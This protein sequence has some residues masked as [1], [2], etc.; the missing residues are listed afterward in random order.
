MKKLYFLWICF[1]WQPSLFGQESE[2][3]AQIGQAYALFHRLQS[4]DNPLDYDLN[5]SRA[6]SLSDAYWKSHPTL[7][8]EQKLKTEPIAYICSSLSITCMQYPNHF[9]LQYDAALQFVED[10]RTAWKRIVAHIGSR[11]SS[12]KA[13]YNWLESIG[14]NK[15]FYQEQEERIKER[16]E[17]IDKK[18]VYLF[19]TITY[20]KQV[21][22]AAIDSLVV[23]IEL[24]FRLLSD[25]NTASTVTTVQNQ[26]EASIRNLDTKNQAMQSL[27]KRVAM[28][29]YL[30]LKT[31]L[32]LKQIQDVDFICDQEWNE[33]IENMN[34]SKLYLENMQKSVFSTA[35]YV[36]KRY[37]VLHIGML[38]LEDL[39]KQL[40]MIRTQKKPCS[41][42]VTQSD[43]AFAT[44]TKKKLFVTVDEWMRLSKVSEVFLTDQPIKLLV[45]MDSPFS[46]KA[47]LQNCQPDDRMMKDVFF[48]ML[49][50][51]NRDFLGID[52]M[53]SLQENETV[54][55]QWLWLMNP[56]AM[57]ITRID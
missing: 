4:T 48:I 54:P 15:K 37:E 45:S 32:Y 49:K 21:H 22:S 35:D 52:K 23:D 16:K 19:D 51:L 50:D 29:P 8:Q 11:P 40:T 2:P 56:A 24:S 3:T 53:K 31:W 1:W 30:Y 18:N 46:F 9:E 34:K 20:Y 41:K 14:F 57:G 25:S 6:K 5:Y 36:L 42:G 47:F 44:V 13:F 12:S 27:V 38:Q 43:I 26:I 39:E 7:T 33:N 55:C 10:A 17:T 28:V